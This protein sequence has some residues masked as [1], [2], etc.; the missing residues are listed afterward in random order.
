MKKIYNFII[1]LI[2]VL[3][4]SFFVNNKQT[5]LPEEFHTEIASI[6]EDDFDTVEE[7]LEPI[8]VQLSFVASCNSNVYHKLYCRYVEKIKSFNMVYFYSVDDAETDGYR[9][10][11]ICLY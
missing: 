10:C 1:L 6:Q 11:R 2:A 5:A 9:R 3:I 4:F 8:E 7:D